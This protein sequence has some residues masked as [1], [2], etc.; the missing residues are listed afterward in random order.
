[1]EAQALSLVTVSR[2]KSHRNTKVLYGKDRKKTVKMDSNYMKIKW[3][4]LQK[5]LPEFKNLGP[6]F[7]WMLL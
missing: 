1:M 2:T 4:K 7:V 6:S 3:L 5:I